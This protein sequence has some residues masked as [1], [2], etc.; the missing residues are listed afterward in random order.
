[1][2]DPTRENLP[3]PTRN[4][5]ARRSAAFGTEI[6]EY[7]NE[8]ILRLPAG[9]HN[10]PG[11][12]QD[13]TLIAISNSYEAIRPAVAAGYLGLDTEP[14]DKNDPSF[15]QKFTDCGWTW[16]ADTQLLHP[17]PIAVKSTNQQASNGI[18]DAMAMFGGRG[19]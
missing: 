9:A 7:V 2:A 12:L 18:H 3:D 13:Q 6:R 17:V 15:I 14:A 16:N 1:M 19:S 8:K 10:F 4:A 11:F 5:V